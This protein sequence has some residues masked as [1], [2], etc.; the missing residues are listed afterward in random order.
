MFNLI[1]ETTWGF[2]DL[3][4]QLFLYQMKNFQLKFYIFKSLTIKMLMHVTL[5]RWCR[6]FWTETH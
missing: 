1:T 2:S 3:N 4:P 6:L 5:R